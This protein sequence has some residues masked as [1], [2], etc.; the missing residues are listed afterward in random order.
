[1]RWHFFM[2]HMKV[3]HRMESIRCHFFNGADL[4]SKK[5]IWIKWNNVLASKEK[6]GLDISSL[7]ALNRA[8]MLKWIGGSIL[9]SHR[10]V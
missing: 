8:L 9:K 6:G 7:Y 3:L 2:V 5:S 10:Y 1:M 4:G